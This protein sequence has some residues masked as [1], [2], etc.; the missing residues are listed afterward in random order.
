MKML[1]LLDSPEKWTQGSLARNK[2]QRRVSVNSPRAVSW[3]LSGALK[4]CYPIEPKAGFV[5][6]RLLKIVGG[7]SLW[8]FN[9]KNSTTFRKIRK[10]LK[11]ANV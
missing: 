5:Y 9:D 11:K 7:Y 2:Q 8:R 10:I 6:N 1:E 3:C 4:L